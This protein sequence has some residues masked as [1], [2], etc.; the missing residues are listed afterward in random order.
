MQSGP[1]ITVIYAFRLLPKV[2][3]ERRDVCVDALGEQPNAET[4]G[5]SWLNEDLRVGALPGTAE[6]WRLGR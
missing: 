2:Y 3:P 4:L 6:R 1:S 5:G